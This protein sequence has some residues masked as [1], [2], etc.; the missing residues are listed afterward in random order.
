MY[1]TKLLFKTQLYSKDL[2]TGCLSMMFGATI[3]IINYS[4][5]RFLLLTMPVNRR[6]IE[7]QTKIV[8]YS[9][10]YCNKGLFDECTD[11]DY[12]NNRLFWYSDPL[13]VMITLRDHYVWSSHTR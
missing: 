5:T 2:I 9:D 13:V 8:H 4:D 10:H 7:E 11:F 1:L 12:R 3:Q 6:Q